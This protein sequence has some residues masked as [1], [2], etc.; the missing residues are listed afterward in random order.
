[1]ISYID[2]PFYPNKE[3]KPKEAQEELR[4]KV[5]EKMLERSKNSN[6]EVIQYIKKEN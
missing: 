2:G 6:V 3:L 1:M 5:Y 4:N